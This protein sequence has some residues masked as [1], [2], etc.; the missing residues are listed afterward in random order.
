MWWSNSLR[1]SGNTGTLFRGPCTGTWC[2]RP[3]R[4]CS[5][6]VRIAAFWMLRS[7]LEYFA[8]FPMCLLGG[9]FSL[10]DLRALLTQTWCGI[11]N[12]KWPFLPMICPFHVTSEVFPELKFSSV[13]LT[14]CNPMNCSMPGLAVHHQLPEFTQTHIHWVLW[15]HPAISSSVVPFSFCPQHQ[16]LIMYKTECQILKD[17][18]FSVFCPLLLTRYFLEGC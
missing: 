3:R 9:L 12:L 7:P 11:T 16:S 6:G 18:Q 8:F 5:P 10:H 15:C 4:T 1:R 14:L 13:A 17:T 2:W